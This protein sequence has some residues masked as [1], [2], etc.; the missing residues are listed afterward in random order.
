MML[1]NGSSMVD[2]TVDKG[3]IPVNGHG[4]QKILLTANWYSQEGAFLGA[5]TVGFVIDISE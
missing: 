4:T 2:A 3:T 1:K 5:K